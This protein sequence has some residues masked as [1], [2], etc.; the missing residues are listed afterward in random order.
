MMNNI[1]CYAAIAPTLANATLYGTFADAVREA[2]ELFSYLDA[3]ALFDDVCGDVWR[4]CKRNGDMRAWEL[5]K[6]H[7]N[8]YCH[9]TGEL[10]DDRV[11]AFTWAGSLY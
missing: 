8:R 10:A 4:E 5:F 2:C 9:A 1:T 6:S 11:L 3:I 7:V